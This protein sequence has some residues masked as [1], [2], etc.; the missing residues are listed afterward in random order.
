MILD[1]HI[2]T[3]IYIYVGFL[4]YYLHL[5][6]CWIGLDLPSPEGQDENSHVAPFQWPEISYLCTCKINN[7]KLTLILTSPRL[8]HTKTVTVYFDDRIKFDEH[9]LKWFTNIISGNVQFLRRQVGIDTCHL[10][11]TYCWYWTFE[12]SRLVV[13]KSTVYRQ[14]GV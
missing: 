2:G 11:D 9:K 14:K 7:S 5:S 10:A 1:T 12:F 13:E 3:I 8:G 4:G 6:M